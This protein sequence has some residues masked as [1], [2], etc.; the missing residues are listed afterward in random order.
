M[1]KDKEFLSIHGTFFNEIY[2]R[3]LILIYWNH[4]EREDKYI[5]NWTIYDFRMKL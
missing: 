4:K 2:R 3:N 5:Y 1:Y